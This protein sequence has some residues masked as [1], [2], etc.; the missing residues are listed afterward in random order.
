MNDASVFVGPGPM[1]SRIFFLWDSNVFRRF[2]YIS[3]LN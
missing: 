1:G 2:F 3:G